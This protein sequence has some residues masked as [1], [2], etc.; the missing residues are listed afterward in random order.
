MKSLRIFLYIVIV[1]F[2]A[3]YFGLAYYVD[4]QFA[5][6][7]YTA[8]YNDC[9]KVWSTRGI[10]GEGIDQNSVESVNK[11]F[12]QGAKGV[13]ID[14]YYDA[15]LMDYVV[16]HGYPYSTPKG[17]I[18]LLSEL[19]NA[20][21]EGHYYYW[22]DFKKLRSLDHAQAVQ[23][24][25][26]LQD[27]S[28]DN[29]LK[30]RIYVEGEAPVNLALFREAGFH[31]IFDTHPAP[32]SRLRS[33]FMITVYKIFYY[34]GDHSVMGME[35]GTLD[36]PVYGAETRE[37][38]KHVPVFLYHLPV[39]EALI[40]ELLPFNA[41]RALLIGNNQSLN[42]HHLNACEPEQAFVKTAED[43]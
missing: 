31:T 28:R 3:S 11:A 34:F 5:K 4:E 12:A 42:F 20:V 43:H 14:I 30:E 17:Q 23:A 19:F 1:F 38:L 9:H 8:T 29:E 25:Q 16:S 35:Y 13:E 32:T 26:R 27:I 24:V 22:L 39:D 15:Q 18:L 33:A 37:R 36:D 10:Y 6:R 7:E 2:I 40:R 21:N 41:V